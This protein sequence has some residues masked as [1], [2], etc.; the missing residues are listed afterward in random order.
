ME[1]DIIT[2]EST[3]QSQ[4]QPTRKPISGTQQ[5]MNQPRPTTQQPHTPGQAIP[6]PTTPL[7][8]IPPALHAQQSTSQRQP[9]SQGVNARPHQEPQE[10][11]AQSQMVHQDHTLATGQGLPP[12]PMR[13][14]QQQAFQSQ[15]S[16]QSPTGE[17]SL[18][19]EQEAIP[20]LHPG[21]PARTT[22]LH[23]TAG[24]QLDNNA[25]TQQPDQG[26]PP[27]A[28]T[29]E[30]PRQPQRR[31]RQ[32]VRRP[33]SLLKELGSLVLK[34]V[35][36][37]SL[38]LITFTFIY[39]FHNVTEPHMSPMV[40]AGDIVIFFRLNR[41]YGM[42]TLVLLNF[43]GE[44]Q[45]RRVVAQTGDTVDIR[46][47]G[48]LVVNGALIHEPMI[49]EQTWRLETGVQFPVTV[50]EGQVFLLGDARETAIDSRVYGPVYMRDTLGS[51]ITVIRRRGM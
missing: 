28:Q 42:D 45:V 14:P 20:T 46:P 41:D 34:I 31:Q 8:H 18:A 19:G 7:P 37:I 16:P 2:P 43:E 35:V 3:P 38:F 39:G 9:L 49:F 11:N 26:T 50:G 40:N 33:P 30:A 25:E 10:H 4:P 29:G 15:P 22:V 36:I 51:V 1:V 5:Y 6:R 48:G 32:V 47:D 24:N 27:P 12:Q 17:Q 13:L 44:R 21:Q 23:S